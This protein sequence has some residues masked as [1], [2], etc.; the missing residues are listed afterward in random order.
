MAHG[1]DF[2]VLFDKLVSHQVASGFY[3]MVTRHEPKAN[4]GTGITAA[5]WFQRLTP[6]AKV[7]GLNITSLRVEF[8]TRLYTS[9][10]AEDQDEIDP[11]VLR[12]VGHLMQ[13][14]SEDFELD[15]VVMEVDLFAAHGP[16]LDAKAGYLRQ[17][18]TLYRVVD[19]LTPLIVADVFDQIPS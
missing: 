19:V 8:I 1:I 3:E 12:A 16:P 18:P 17:G 7:S 15:G 5:S 11:R 10:L 9:M 6:A 13:V 4:P 2:D 14:Y